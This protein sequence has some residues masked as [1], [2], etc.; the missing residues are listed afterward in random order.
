MARA[1]RWNAFLLS[2]RRK[3]PQADRQE[4]FTRGR[5]AAALASAAVVALGAALAATPAKASLFSG[6][7]LDK[8]ADIMAIVVLIVVPIVVIVVFW[9]VH[10]LPERF[11]EKRHHPQTAAIQVLCLLSLVFGGLLWP[12]AWLWAFTRPVLHKA[13]YGTDVDAEWHETMGEKARAGELVDEQIAHLREE[14]DAMAARG[15]LP[16]NL[17]QLRNDLDSLKPAAPSV[18]PAAGRTA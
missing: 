5:R 1:I 6:E 2:M 17:R 11:A 13:A 15:A 3:L 18:L 7:A 8:V 16:A 10:V 4:R 14:L 12:I 9:L